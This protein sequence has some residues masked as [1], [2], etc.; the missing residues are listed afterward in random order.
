MTIELNDGHAQDL[1]QGSGFVLIQKDDAGVVHSVHISDD[2]LEA[3][4][5]AR[6]QAA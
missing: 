2:D 4:R 5:A 1:G 3:M 6:A